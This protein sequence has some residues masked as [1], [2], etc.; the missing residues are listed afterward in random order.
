MKHEELV[1]EAYA[2]LG[3]YDPRI[4]CTK[5]LKINR[6]RISISYTN[7][8]PLN[9]RG[10]N[11]YDELMRNTGR[12]TF[13]LI[14]SVC[15]AAQGKRVAF[16]CSRNMR[17]HFI[18]FV[19]R[20]SRALGLGVKE[21]PPKEVR[22]KLTNRRTIEIGPSG[23]MVFVALPS[24][25][26]N[27]RSA[28]EVNLRGM[29]FDSIAIDNFILDQQESHQHINDLI[30]HACH[31]TI[32]YIGMSKLKKKPDSFTVEN[33]TTFR[34]GDL[35]ESPWG[36]AMIVDVY[37]DSQYMSLLVNGKKELMYRNDLRLFVKC[38][39]VDA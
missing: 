38:D 34:N 32:T 27:Y 7:F 14:V 37:H 28:I 17:D 6:R 19:I 2:H 24:H 36:I 13:D 26:E 18:S 11:E 10:I 20:V 3:L 8:G 4:H 22:Q 5:M 39:P 33:Y 1:K 9:N 16:L 23:N 21:G 25:T 15:H 35:I 29:T 30:A 12:S 31:N